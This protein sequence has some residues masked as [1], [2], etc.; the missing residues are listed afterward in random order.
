[1]Q[2]FEVYLCTVYFALLYVSLWIHR[3]KSKNQIKNIYIL[4]NI[5]ITVACV[6]GLHRYLYTATNQ[7]DEGTI[8]GFLQLRLRSCR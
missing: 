2:R 5:I 4:L 7:T 3:S 6:Q 1:M 8:F